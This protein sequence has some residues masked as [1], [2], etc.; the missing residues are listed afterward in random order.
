MGAAHRYI[1][2]AS[3]R[4]LA[5]MFNLPCPHK[6]KPYAFANDKVLQWRNAAN[7][8]DMDVLEV[9]SSD[10]V[11]LGK[12]I[13]NP[14]YDVKTFH[15]APNADVLDQVI[16]IAD[17]V[18]KV[19]A[20]YEIHTTK[21]T[22]GSAV[23]CTVRKSADGV[24]IANGTALC[25]ALSMK[26]T[27]DTVQEATLSTTASDLVLAENDRISVDLSGVTDLAG[28]C[29]VLVVSPGKKSQTAVLRGVANGD[30]ADRIF[31]LANRPMLITGMK[32][33]VGTAG[34]N[35]SAVVAQVTLDVAADAPGAGDNILTNN[36]A[37]GFNLKNTINTI[38]EGAL[39]SSYIKMAA[40]DFLS[41]DFAGTLT[42]AAGVFIQ[43]EFQANHQYEDVVFFSPN[44]GAVLVE[45]SFFIADRNYEIV[46]ASAV[47]DVDSG[48][49]TNF[50]L[51]RDTGTN[52]PGDG[53]DLLDNDS[54]DGFQTDANA[55]TSEVATWKDARNNH[56]LTGDRLSID[57]NG[58]LTSL[59]GVVVN[60][61]LKPE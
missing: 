9:D 59:V 34:T 36:T 4:W 60:V 47:W 28:V 42:A 14:D 40:G 46:A 11:R 23:T 22:D 13:L 49:A 35:G 50:Q 55:R 1:V 57:P 32:A 26:T 29:L 56:L 43:V 54:N 18:R 30:L 15:I 17:G 37:G 51:V 8:T 10:N 33:C 45:E 12:Q 53:T 2:A 44:D 6:G 24:T 27:D 19:E 16:W 7:D 61:T 25:T 58:T 48:A 5:N 3:N 31:F 39:D 21:D 38:E 52:S 20:I 41:V